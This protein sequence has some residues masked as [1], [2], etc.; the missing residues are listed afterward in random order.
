MGGYLR[1]WLAERVPRLFWP[2]LVVWWRVGTKWIIPPCTVISTVIRSF[3]LKVNV[4]GWCSTRPPGIKTNWA[5]MGSCKPRWVN[6]ASVYTWT[7]CCYLLLSN[8]NVTSQLMDVWITERSKSS[9]GSCC[10][11]Q[12]WTSYLSAILRTAVCFRLWTWGTSW[13][14]RGRM[15]PSLMPKASYSPTS[16]TSGV[17]C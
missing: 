12:N 14:I 16:S 1:R 6:S 9:A 13:R 15:P 8:R 4:P 7:N 5:V 3:V 11:D 10:G 17:R 2:C